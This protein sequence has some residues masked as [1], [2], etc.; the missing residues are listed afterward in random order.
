MFPA[1]LTRVIAAGE[2]SGNL[3]TSLDRCAVH[4]ER[5]HEVRAKVRGALMYPVI[6]L[7]LAVVV[8]IFL[9]IVVIPNF[10]SIFETMGAGDNLPWPTRL[11]ISIADVARRYFP[12]LALG[13]LVLAYG[14]MKYLQTPEGRYRFDALLLRAPVVKQLTMLDGVSRFCRTMAAL[15]NTGIP[16]VQGLALVETAVGNKVLGKA[17]ADTRDAVRRGERI[18]TPLQRTKRFPP[19]V[20]Q[21]IAVGE[22]TGQVG[23]MLDK[24]ADYYER[25]LTLL[26]D[27]LSKLIEPI[28]IIFLAVIVGFIV[29][30]VALPMFEMWTII[31]G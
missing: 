2:A 24:L 26:T 8:C 23:T 17:L 29:I 30:S 13:F 5:E 4:F 15:S 25:D 16:L 20:S 9:V 3:D 10:A 31:G 19:M 14:G 27:S 11:M 7:C 21:M 12:V 18:S 6:V 28:M 1:I 22:E